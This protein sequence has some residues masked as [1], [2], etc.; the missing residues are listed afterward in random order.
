MAIK[1]QPAFGQVLICD[2]PE[3]FEEPEM[4]KRRPVI[5][6]S[7]KNRT[8]QRLST[9]VPLSTTRPLYRSAYAVPVMLPS[10]ISEKFDSLECWAK[11]DLLYSFSWSRLNIPYDK[12]GYE[13]RYNTLIL[14][15][16]TMC[17][18]LTGVLAGMGVG[19]SVRFERD[20]YQV[21]D[22]RDIL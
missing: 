18:I 2:F 10:R 4:V 20:S 22:F 5:C 6:L 13:R 7:P 1:Y 15:P 19:G 16:G 11:C 12:F 17:E 14:P 21:F 9:V 8:R 3:E